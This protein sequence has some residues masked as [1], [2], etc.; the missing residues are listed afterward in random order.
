MKSREEVIEEMRR[1]VLAPPGPPLEATREFLQTYCLDHTRAE[2]EQFI[3]TM[4]NQNTNTLYRGLVGMEALLAGPP[5]EPGVL[6]ELVAVDAGWPLRDDNSDE[7]ARVVLRVLAAS[8][9]KHL[10]AAGVDVPSTS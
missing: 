6:R 2:A 8:V 7:G 3:A 4:A 5:P 1:R 9:R 10:A